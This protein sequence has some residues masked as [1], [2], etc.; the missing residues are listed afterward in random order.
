MS[1]PSTTD[2]MENHVSTHDACVL[3]V[4]RLLD[5]DQADAGGSG[6]AIDNERAGIS[7]PG[8]SL[9]D[10]NLSTPYCPRLH[11]PT[12][13]SKFPSGH[14]RSNVTASQR[15]RK[16]PLILATLRLSKDWMSLW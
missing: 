13:M 5:D 3:T 15:T 2:G 6:L 10:A 1:Q 16:A 7:V 8:F 4:V 12:L 11:L 14:H 9:L